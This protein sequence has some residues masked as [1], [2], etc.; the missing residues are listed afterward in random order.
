MRY[1]L[2][3]AV[4]FFCLNAAAPAY[5]I[6]P[7]PA[8]T[9][10]SRPEPPADAGNTV[11]PPLADA[12]SNTPDADPAVDAGDYPDTGCSD[13]V[14]DLVL[15]DFDASFDA[16]PVDSGRRRRRV[17]TVDAGDVPDDG[18]FGCS[19]S[20]VSSLLWLLPLLATR[21]RRS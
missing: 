14:C 16:G 8:D 7:Q 9:G 10:E 6:R 17:V 11:A 5:A 13:G 1:A 21:R 2:R 19:A 15:P 3:L 4:V 12:G 20:G 18:M